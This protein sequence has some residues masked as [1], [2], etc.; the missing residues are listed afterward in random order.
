LDGW[1]VIAAAFFV[2]VFGGFRM[3]D[4]EKPAGRRQRATTVRKFG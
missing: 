4:K 2:M 3:T 1:S